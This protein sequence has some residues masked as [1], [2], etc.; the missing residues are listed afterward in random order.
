MGGGGVVPACAFLLLLL[1]RRAQGSLPF[2]GWTSCLGLF[3]ECNLGDLEMDL[4][5]QKSQAMAA[6]PGML[7]AKSTP[8]KLSILLPITHKWMQLECFIYIMFK[9]EDS[10]VLFNGLI[11]Q[12]VPLG[13]LMDIPASW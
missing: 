2:P 3:H 1:L 9:H 4:E 6:R 8:E 7:L 10:L 5:V 13:I 11:T 12:A